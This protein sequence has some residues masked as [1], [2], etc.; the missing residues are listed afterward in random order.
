MAS[1]ISSTTLTTTTKAQWHFVLHGGCSETCADADRQRETI[2]NLQAV[3]ESVTR[4]LNQGAT[5]KEAVV[6]A[7]AGLEDCPTFNAGHGAALNENGIHQVSPFTR[8][9]Y[10]VLTIRQ[11]EA[12][13]VDGASKTYGA[14]GLLETTKN[15]IRLANELLEHGPHT[16]MVGTAADDMA[17]KLGLEKVPNSYFSTAFRKGLWERSKGN[18]IVSGANGTVGAVV[19]DSYGQ[20]AAG[21]STGGGTGK[22]DGRLGD[23][24][25]LGAGLYADD[26]VSVVW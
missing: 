17:K 26:R 1:I 10:Y 5:A 12:G 11:L 3:A 14:V 6:L 21:G 22:M 4:A 15:P 24:A 2:E 18:K 16:I 25:I 20:L 9:R 7:V 13:L 19:L 23:T 8:D